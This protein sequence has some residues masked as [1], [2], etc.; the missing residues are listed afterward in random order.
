METSPKTPSLGND[1]IPLIAELQSQA[2]QMKLQ[3]ILKKSCLMRVTFLKKK[4]IDEYAPLQTNKNAKILGITLSNDLSFGD[5]ISKITAKAAG[6][7]KSFANLRRF[8]MTE[9]LVL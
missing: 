3:L 1:R 2:D 9:Q 5:Q 6:F 8:R 4:S 7:P